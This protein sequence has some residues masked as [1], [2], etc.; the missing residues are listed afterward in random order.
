[1]NYLVLA[2][3]KNATIVTIGGVEQQLSESLLR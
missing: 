1:M 3:G 2:M